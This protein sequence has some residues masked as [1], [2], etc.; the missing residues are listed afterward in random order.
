MFIGKIVQCNFQKRIAFFF[1]TSELRA[2]GKMCGD[3]YFAYNALFA[4]CQ[5]ER[6][7][8]MKENKTEFTINS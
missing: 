1:H 5:N 6:K 8:E 4:R 2:M 3:E 7:R